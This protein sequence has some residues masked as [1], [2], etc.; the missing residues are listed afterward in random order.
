MQE[1]PHFCGRSPQKGVSA[2]EARGFMRIAPGS[3]ICPICCWACAGTFAGKGG[4]QVRCTPG[5]CHRL[6]WGCAA[7]APAEAQR[8][9]G[10]SSASIAWRP[11]GGPHSRSQRPPRAPSAG[12]LCSLQRRRACRG[13]RGENRRRKRGGQREIRGGRGG[14]KG[15][16]RGGIRGNKGGLEQGGRQGTLRLISSKKSPALVRRPLLVAPVSSA[17]SSGMRSSLPAVGNRRPS[18][19]PN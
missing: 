10:I 4:G 3:S 16:K 9:P 5:L 12:G 7:A 14:E 6:I 11:E 17:T 19:T 8:A 15:K 2:P 1:L 18:Q 13:Q